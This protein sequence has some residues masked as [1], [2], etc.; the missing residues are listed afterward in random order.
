MQALSPKKDHTTYDHLAAVLDSAVVERLAQQLKVLGE[1]N[2]LRI[3][4]LL[5]EG[6]QCNCELSN[7]LQMAP[8]LISHHLRILREV[9]LVDVERDAADAR[10]IYYSL[11]QAALTEL[12]TTFNAFFNQAH[13]KDRHPAC[14]PQSNVVRTE[15]ILVTT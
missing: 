1:P 6:A 2:R 15:D 14:G 4:E 3:V 5:C 7:A 8:N 10:W 9:G 12:M 13:I 11:N